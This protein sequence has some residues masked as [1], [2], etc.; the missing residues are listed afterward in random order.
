MPNE[1]R[2]APHLPLAGNR[3][4]R[5]PGRRRHRAYWATGD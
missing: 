5:L 2:V 1:R 4:G 3:P